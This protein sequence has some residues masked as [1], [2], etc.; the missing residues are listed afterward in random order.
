MLKLR[1]HN[2]PPDGLT[3]GLVDIML[4]G[5]SAADPFLIFDVDIR[6]GGSYL[7]ALWRKHHAWLLTEWQRRGGDGQPWGAQFDEVAT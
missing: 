4:T 1:I 6:D 5:D 7:P 2:R 3:P